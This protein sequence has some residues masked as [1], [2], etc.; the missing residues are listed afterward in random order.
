MGD[1]PA[2]AS[3]IR[4]RANGRADARRHAAYDR[5]AE[6]HRALR[7]ARADLAAAERKVKDEA[8]AAAVDITAL[9]PGCLIRT[10]WG[11]REVATVNKVSVS[12]VTGESWSTLVRFAKILEVQPSPAQRD[13]AMSQH[14]AG[15]S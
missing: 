9:V 15:K 1:D 2:V 5:E 11:W 6:A 3:G 13:A 7:T 14:P 12:I 10:K 8:D 4:R